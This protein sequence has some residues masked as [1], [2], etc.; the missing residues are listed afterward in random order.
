MIDIELKGID[1]IKNSI[2]AYYETKYEI[3]IQYQSISPSI[4]N[5]LKIRNIKIKAK[6]KQELSLNCKEL[7]IHYNILKLIFKKSFSGSFYKIS[8]N[9]LDVNLDNNIEKFISRLRF[10]A[11]KKK[12]PE[13]NNVLIENLSHLNISGKNINIKYTDKN[14]VY[15][16]IIRSFSGKITDR[17]DFKCKMSTVLTFSGNGKKHE[18]VNQTSI[19]FPANL[20]ANPQKKN[21]SLKQFSTTINIAGRIDFKD[22][23]GVMF[24]Q[25][26]N[27]QYNKIRFTNQNFIF[28][29]NRQ[30][31]VIEKE[32]DGLPYDY[33]IRYENKKGLFYNINLKNTLLKDVL[34]LTSINRKYIVFMPAI[35]NFSCNGYYYNKQVNQFTCRGL[36]KYQKFLAQD[37]VVIQFN[38]ELDGK[39]I[40][41]K[42]FIMVQ[43]L[44]SER[45]CDLEGIFNLTNYKFSGK[46]YFHNFS[47]FQFIINSRI[48][49]IE[50]NG[51]DRYQID[52]NYLFVN[53]AD[54]GREVIEVN[55]NKKQISFYTSY[56]G[57]NFFVDGKLDLDR[58]NFFCQ[59]NMSHSPVLPLI[60]L[61]NL[62]K[63]PSIKDY[64]IN[65]KIITMF[66]GKKW[67]VDARDLA[68]YNENKKRLCN[69]N[70]DF[71][72]SR[73]RIY[74]SVI[75]IL[76]RN[77]NAVLWLS[78]HKPLFLF[79]NVQ[80]N[81]IVYPLKIS[82]KNNRTIEISGD[83][84][85]K[86]IVSVPNRKIS[87]NIS[88][89]PFEYNDKILLFNLNTNIFIENRNPVIPDSYIQIK[90]IS[91]FGYHNVIIS[92]NFQFNEDRLLISSL[93][94]QDPYSNLIGEG[95]FIVNWQ[96]MVENGNSL[97]LIGKSFLKDKN[98][99]EYY[100]F[101]YTMDNEQII[102][103]LYGN[104]FPVQKIS[105]GKVSGYLSF[106]IQ[107]S[108]AILD[109][110]I[111]FNFELKQGRLS[112]NPLEFNL[113][114]TKQE[115]GII[116]NNGEIVFNFLSC[117]IKNGFYLYD[118]DDTDLNDSLKLDLALKYQLLNRRLE[119]DVNFNLMGE[120][121]LNWGNEF[122]LNIDF[123]NIFYSELNR[124]GIPVKQIKKDD[125]IL[126][127]TG[128]ESELLVYDLNHKIVDF[129]LKNSGEWNFHFFHKDELV[130]N[131]QGKL[132]NQNLNGELQFLN[133]P[134]ALISDYISSYFSIYA[135]YLN[136]T[137]KLTGTLDDPKINGRINVLNGV[138]RIMRLNIV[139]MENISGFIECKENILYFSN[140]NA[141]S[142]DG[143][144][145]GNG[146]LVLNGY[147]I[148]DF[149]YN[150]TTTP[151][152]INY[153]YTPIS[154]SGLCSIDLD[155]LK[156]EDGIMI[157][158]ELIM[159]DVYIT[160]KPPDGTAVKKNPFYLDWV[161]IAGTKVRFE[162]P[163]FDFYLIS[164]S[165]L[166]AHYSSLD[167]EYSLDGDINFKH[168]TITYLSNTFQIT[169]GKLKF[170]A[171]E[172]EINPGFQVNAVKRIR[173][174]KEA[175]Q[176]F[177]H[178]NGR[179]NNYEPRFTSI[180]YRNNDEINYLLGLST[181]TEGQYAQNP[182]IL[183][184][185]SDQISENLL[186]PFE[187]QIR[188]SG[189]F[190]V[191]SVNTRLVSNLIKGTLN[192]NEFNLIDNTDITFGWYLMNELYFES[193]LSFKNKN[194]LPNRD[195]FLSFQD[196][197]VDLKLMLELDL[198]FLSIAYHFMP[199]GID[200]LNQ[201]PAR[202]LNS[203]HQW[204]LE[205]NINF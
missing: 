188:K 52:C 127:A 68:F 194:N 175:V 149:H 7:R 121:L 46:V 119:T 163:F 148:E 124:Y 73:L 78:K 4:L 180:P 169:K 137:V 41:I 190:D 54:L 161:I 16:N 10:S 84:T 183:A 191:F 83:K 13:N 53:N 104:R 22:F 91:L 45:Y 48:D 6:N 57:N 19:L 81:D 144:L 103:R 72:H 134:P 138:G 98:T 51:P 110:D 95:E 11:V 123:S 200:Q 153:D 195:T 71:R 157:R 33:H 171:E 15:T 12:E 97:K 174:R 74:N 2:I 39:T 38:T 9:D 60:Q 35:L 152:P 172:N 36:V 113:N 189:V 69:L 115:N 90:N 106:N 131:S 166:K 49:F 18:L 114:M 27:I 167:N 122:I 135:G 24:C 204:S 62:P 28:K 43:G 3:N 146:I 193:L 108:G 63:Q 37:D 162:Y 21:T 181:D 158:G 31:I 164:G 139:P 203:Q 85:H 186:S 80:L 156:Y 165:Q 187:E 141:H 92:A 5:Y 44:N 109:P 89:L 201:D 125:F 70:F 94:Y 199:V 202:F 178:I 32:K 17:F 155:L 160:I 176:I 34:N 173:Q 126:V 88:D 76:N 50:K 120:N 136:G 66:R 56:S 8:I 30:A 107:I 101:D 14:F 26:N 112:G 58:L 198:P 29:I 159:H 142:K 154:A 42:Q 147:S 99:K 65:G 47:L 118:K 196:L 184:D 150:L 140:F 79:G 143:L 185:T 96:D 87:M 61:F 145:H 179:L 64:H 82:W 102:G 168:G 151:I 130:I 170:F 25:T 67:E 197:G 177:L 132:N 77:L 116:F 1:K 100:L 129:M 59:T 86:I 20:S 23:S 40:D 93:N 182:D 133:Y 75:D 205:F 105:A 117:N 55:T 128:S 192:E 111:R